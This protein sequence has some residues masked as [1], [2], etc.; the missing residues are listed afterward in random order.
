[1]SRQETIMA[2][3]QKTLNM[4][5][6]RDPASRYYALFQEALETATGCD[7]EDGLGGYIPAHD[8]KSV[9]ATETNAGQIMVAAAIMFTG[10]R[11]AE[12]IR[13]GLAEIA[14][15]MEQTEQ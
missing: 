2:G 8:T 12:T 15:A 9:A 3:I 7:A 5:G 13:Q 6:D 4:H 10:E 14:D 11:I 1:M